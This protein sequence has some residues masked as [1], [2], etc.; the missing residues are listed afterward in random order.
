MTPEHTETVS[1]EIAR[2]T[3]LAADGQMTLAVKSFDLAREMAHIWADPAGLDKVTTREKV[4]L[5]K[6]RDRYRQIHFKHGAGEERTSLLVMGDSLGLPRADRMGGSY[7]GGEN[8]YPWMLGYEVHGFQP[9]AICQ[10]YFTTADALAILRQEPALAETETAIIHLGLNDCATRMFLEHERLALSLLAADQREAFVDFARK[11]RKAILKYLPNR[12]YVAPETFRQN[13]DLLVDCLQRSGCKKIAL[14]TIIL[15][16]SR[17]WAGTPGMAAN[18][19]RYNAEIMAAATRNDVM[20]FDLDRLV[21]ER[22]NDT[23][24]ISDGMHLSD[25]GHTLFTREVVKLL[26]S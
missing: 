13:L 24:L 6:E 21:A 4:G 22:G 8:T 14:T 23:M 1:Q 25:E 12:H 15:P 26:K 3:A 11:N 19:G 7:K 10:R 20:L 16:P 9:T 2:A 18:F 5:S 17:S